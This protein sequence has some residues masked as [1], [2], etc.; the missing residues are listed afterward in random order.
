MPGRPDIS[1]IMRPYRGSLGR[2]R[3]A[4]GSPIALGVDRDGA[5][6]HCV[7]PLPVKMT[8]TVLKVILAFL[9]ALIT[10]LV[11]CSG[12][13]GGFWVSTQIGGV[14]VTNLTWKETVWPHTN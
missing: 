14:G 13:L 8:P 5:G 1:N 4:A 11:A 9:L 7:I 2:A 10:L 6:N 12:R 3:V